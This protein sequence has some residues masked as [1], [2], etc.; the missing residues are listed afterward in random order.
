MPEAYKNKIYMFTDHF[1]SY[2]SVILSEQH[3][4]VDKGTGLTNTV[5]R[6]NNILCQRVSRLVRKTLSF[7]KSKKN[8]IKSVH[9][10]IDDYIMMQRMKRSDLTYR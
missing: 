4:D 3:Q 5:E 6:F 7:S 9:L 1:I 2:K 10:F 8:L